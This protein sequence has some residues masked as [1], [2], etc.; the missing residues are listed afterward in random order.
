MEAR[1]WQT[2]PLQAFYVQMARKTASR[3]AQREAR[4]ESRG[5]QRTAEMPDQIPARSRVLASLWTP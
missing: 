1:A 5:S 2:G 4:P 3:T